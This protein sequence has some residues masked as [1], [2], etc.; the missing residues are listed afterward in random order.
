MTWTD[1]IWTWD[2]TSPVAARPGSASKSA[3]LTGAVVIEQFASRPW[4]LDHC[5]PCR[6]LQCSLE[7]LG[8]G[9]GAGSWKME[10]DDALHR[11]RWCRANDRGRTPESRIRGGAGRR[12][13]GSRRCPL[14][15]L[16]ADAQQVKYL[17]EKLYLSDFMC[18]TCAG[19]AKVTSTDNP[20]APRSSGPVIPYSHAKSTSAPAPR[21]R[22]LCLCACADSNASDLSP[23][24]RPD[25]PAKGRLSRELAEGPARS[26]A[27]D[28]F[29]DETFWT[30]TLRMHE[31]IRTSVS[32]NDGAWPSASRSMPTRC[33]PKSR[34]VSR[35]NR[36]V[37]TTPRPP[38]P[39][40]SWAPFSA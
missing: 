24:L 27:T 17:L 3:F 26:S 19:A 28:T 21:W 2:H 25:K 7:P 23:D 35:M 11:G 30:D 8:I 34:L 12:V 16:T 10:S 37:W 15:L 31:V 38:S 5:P 14:V 9:A 32:P 36:S 39:C 6:G 20:R 18:L 1:E 40:S 29:G 13:E 22:L 4:I 33:P